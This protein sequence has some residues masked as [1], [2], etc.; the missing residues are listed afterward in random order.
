VLEPYLTTADVAVHVTNWASRKWGKC[1]T[2]RQAAAT[3]SVIVLSASG[4]DADQYG[5]RWVHT[6]IAAPSMS[7]MSCTRPPEVTNALGRAGERRV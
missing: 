7:E 4:I 6:I 2:G 3:K 5:R 1:W